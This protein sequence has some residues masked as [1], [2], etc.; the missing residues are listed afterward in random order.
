M[1]LLVPCFS[2]VASSFS[3]VLPSE[4]ARNSGGIPRG[5]LKTTLRIGRLVA[6]VQVGRRSVVKDPTAFMIYQF[7]DCALDTERREFRRGGV[8]VPLE[9]QVFDLLEFL[10]R[11]RERVVRKDD[12]FNAVWGGRAVSDAAL[13]TRLSAARA[14]IGDRGAQQRLIRTIRTKGFR[15][16][17]TLREVA[18]PPYAAGQGGSSAFFADHPAIAVLPIASISGD[19]VLDAVAD[20]I[21]E[22]LMAALSKIGWLHVAPRTASFVHKGDGL[23]APQLARTLGVRYLLQGA[24]RNAQ[25]RRR[26]TIHLVDAIVPRQVWAESYDLDMAPAFAAQDA[27]CKNVMAA[28]EPQLYLAEH[29]RVARKSAVSLNGWE[30]IVRALSLMN[31]RDKKSVAAAR[32]L[33]RK[34]VAIDPRSAQAHSLLSIVN[35]LRLHMSWAERRAITPA[36]LA[37]ARTA[38][39]LNPDDP[40][41][42]AALGYALIWKQPEDAIVPF[43]RAIGLNPNFAIGHYFWALAAAYAGHHNQ[44]LPHAALAE[45][46]A[47][48]DL[49]AR[50]YAGAHDNVRA[51]GCFAVERYDDGAEY[52]RRAAVYLPNSPTAYRA[53]IINLA[54]K[55][56]THDA[57]RALRTLRRLAPEMTQNWIRR[58]AVWAGAAAMK[59]YVD[60]FRI[61]G[62]E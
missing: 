19:R 21:T 1:R 29:F 51:T 3:Q 49:L 33:L 31:S 4:H 40:W 24:I 14:A 39:A 5:Y 30:C 61:A 9:P 32:A 15:F 35:T 57:R 50:G 8:S 12:V 17:G 23:G 59:R 56:Q 55:G 22:E 36:A 47:R 7:E 18:T 52:A 13:D 25:G 58:N 27:I 46:F 53:M 2:L 38:L 62:L 28:I 48:R 10:I 6:I 20:G 16:V 26:M 60:A 44:V 34:A 42:H 37:S 54:L 41:A 43:E 45:R 11:N